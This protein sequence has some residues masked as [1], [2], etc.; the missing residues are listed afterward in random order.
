MLEVKWHHQDSGHTTLL[1]SSPLPSCYPKVNE[2]DRAGKNIPGLTFSCHLR[3][4]EDSS[5]ALK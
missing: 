4:E 1:S 3:R 5:T 2:G